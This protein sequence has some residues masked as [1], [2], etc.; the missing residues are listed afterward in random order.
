[1]LQLRMLFRPRLRPEGH[2]AAAIASVLVAQVS[3]PGTQSGSLL[4]AQWQR[5]T[6]LFAGH[7]H[8][9]SVAR[10]PAER[11]AVLVGHTE[12]IVGLLSMWTED[13]HVV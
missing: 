1:M 11:L 13:S 2:P 5:V 8:S 12:I 9:D 7:R 10:K 6:N 4:L 3:P